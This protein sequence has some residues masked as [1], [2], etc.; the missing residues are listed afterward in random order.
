PSTSDLLRAEREMFNDTHDATGAAL[1]VASNLPGFAADA[2]RLQ[3]EP[4]ERLIDAPFEVRAVRIASTLA[5]RGVTSE[6]AS[7]A[8]TLLG[9][10]APALAQLM[11]ESLAAAR[12]NPAGVEIYEKAA[13][14]SAALMKNSPAIIGA[15]LSLQLPVRLDA[16]ANQNLVETVSA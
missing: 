9:I 16:P 7:A 6:T 1:I 12:V 13:T 2:A 4:I 11:D 14:A 15:D 3:H 8:T 5:A 10:E